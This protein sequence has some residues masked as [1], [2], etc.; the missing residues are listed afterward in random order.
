MGTMCTWCN[1]MLCEGIGKSGLKLFPLPG[2]GDICLK[3]SMFLSVSDKS[4]VKEECA[5]FIDWVINDERAAAIL[6]GERGIPSS[7]AMRQY[8]LDYEVPSAQLKEMLSYYKDQI[9]NAGQ[10]AAPQP[11]GMIELEEVFQEIGTAAFYGEI[12]VDAAAEC[13]RREAE[14]IFAEYT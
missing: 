12:S 5:E 4:G 2:N 10:P 8:L 1:Y 14:R 3:P 9:K 7:V 13:F 11:A 6:R